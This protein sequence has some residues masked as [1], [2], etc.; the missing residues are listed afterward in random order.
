ML[1]PV[2]VDAVEP[3]EVPDVMPDA[4][5]DDQLM[6]A[7]AGGDTGAFDVLYA[8]HEGALFRFVRRLL[9]IRL[10]AEVDEVFQETWVRIIT[11]RDSFSPQGA[12]WR[13]WAFTIAHNLAMDRLRAS[14]RQMVVH[15]HDDDDEGLEAVQRVSGR[16][17]N[18]QGQPVDAAHPSAEDAAFWRSAGKRLLAC[19][20][21]LPDDQRAAFLLHHEDGFTVEAMAAA[22]DVGFETVRSRLRYG[23]KK[24]RGCMERYLSVL[25]EGA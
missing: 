21:E 13:T 17:L 19:L 1:S 22:L 3:A 2:P 25:G 5:P 23:L 12:A 4:M 7:Y 8:R 9:G 18:G 16:L 24:L 20:N 15:V 14:G 6:L 11:A 10:A